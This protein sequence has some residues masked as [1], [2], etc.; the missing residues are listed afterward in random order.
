METKTRRREKERKMFVC[1]TKDHSP[2]RIQ[3]DK[4][5]KS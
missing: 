4:E 5:E 1:S 2:S 3:R